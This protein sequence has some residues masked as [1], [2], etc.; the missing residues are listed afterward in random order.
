MARPKPRWE[1]GRHRSCTFI[2]VNADPCRVLRNLE[3]CHRTDGFCAITA[4]R[5]PSSGFNEKGAGPGLPHTRA[6]DGAYLG[7]GVESYPAHA[8][9]HGSPAHGHSSF[10]ALPRASESCL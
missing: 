3:I 4:M 2:A 8:A 5:G 10:T 9:A 7:L 6:S 1:H